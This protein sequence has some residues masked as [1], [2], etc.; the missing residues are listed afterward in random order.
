MFYFIKST[1][2]LRVSQEEEIE[3]VDITEDGI[4]T[5]PQMFVN[6]MP[7]GSVFLP[8]LRDLAM[9]KS[10]AAENHTAQV[11]FSEPV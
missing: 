10:A 5:Y 1:V 3:G 8:T 7:V 4:Y 9:A 2:G 11:A 6:D